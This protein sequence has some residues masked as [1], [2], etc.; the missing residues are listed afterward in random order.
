LGGA[1]TRRWVH[2][3]ARVGH[4]A[5]GIVYILVGALAVAASID[6]HRRPA[7]PADAL[8]RLRATDLGAV[9]TVIIA[10]G[11]IADAL[12][13]ALRAWR[14]F[15]RVGAG[16]RGLIQRAGV[17]F[18]GLLHLGLAVA[19]ARLVLG[20]DTGDTL[21]S[22]TKGWLAFAFTL[23]VGPWLVA[24]AAGVTFAVAAVTIYRGIAPRVLARLN[25]AH[26]H[27]RLAWAASLFARLGLLAR[28]AIY[29]VIA[30]FLIAAAYHHS[31]SQARAVGGAMRFLQH[32]RDGRWLLAAIALGFVA[33][34]AVEIIRARH[35]TI[36][37]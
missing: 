28:G 26:L 25:L 15:D 17:A 5:T 7:G 37:T 36:R 6:R 35:R 30:V 27:E 22:Q 10:V 31:A 24:L 2:G 20:Y 13:Q 11:L 21:E 3:A 12:W 32:D 19:A 18:S 8:Y 16:L 23:P 34:G 1:A 4:V 9:A 14:D 29:A 33:N